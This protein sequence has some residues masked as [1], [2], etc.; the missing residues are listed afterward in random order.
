MLALEVI[1]AFILELIGDFILKA[2][3]NG[4]I[5]EFF[6]DFI[7]EVISFKWFQLTHNE[8]S[9][10]FLPGLGYGELEH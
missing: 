3:I 8:D 1:E 4:F 5:F 9:T 10:E 6:G 7:L 2:I